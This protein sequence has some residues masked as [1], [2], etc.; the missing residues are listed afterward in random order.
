MLLILYGITDLHSH[1]CVALLHEL[2]CAEDLWINGV[3]MELQSQG[4]DVGSQLLVVLDHRVVLGDV[5]Q[6]VSLHID[7]R[8]SLLG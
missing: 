5:R 2:P 3:R 4:D 7:R 6:F 8:A 1:L